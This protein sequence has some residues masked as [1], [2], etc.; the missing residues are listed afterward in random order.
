MS[1]IP[2]SSITCDNT[3]S[4]V[5]IWVYVSTNFWFKV[6]SLVLIEVEFLFSS[7]T[8]VICDNTILVDDWY[9]G[10]T[11]LNFYTFV[12][13]YYII[14]FSKNIVYFFIKFLINIINLFYIY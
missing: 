3:E 1:S 5:I 10:S 2:N 11:K 14:F 6:I 12:I 4:V 7:S 13:I 8:S 9:F